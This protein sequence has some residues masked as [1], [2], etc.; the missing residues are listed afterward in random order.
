MSAA[1]AE[2]SGSVATSARR[3]QLASGVIHVNSS[4]QKLGVSGSEDNPILSLLYFEFI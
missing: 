1:T 4:G 2:F 3:V